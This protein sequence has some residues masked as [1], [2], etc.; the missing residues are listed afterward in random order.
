MSLKPTANHLYLL[1]SLS[2]IETAFNMDNMCD[3]S[4]VD[5]YS[6]LIHYYAAQNH[7]QIL[8]SILYNY[9]HI[10]CISHLTSLQPNL[11]AD[12][13]LMISFKKDGS[14]KSFQASFQSA[15]CLPNESS[16]QR[17]S[18]EHCAAL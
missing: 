6:A 12:M 7:V 3:I 13:L 1:C 4:K 15:R 16:S 17:P 18:S 2:L 9:V 10:T 14:Q 11:K 8:I 5:T